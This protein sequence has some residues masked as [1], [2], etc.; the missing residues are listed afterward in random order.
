MQTVVQDMDDARR[1]T[2][3]ILAISTLL[4]V[5]AGIVLA[6]AVSRKITSGL[7][8]AVERAKVIAAGDLRGRDLLAHSQDEVGDLG[9][10]MNDMQHN[11]RSLLL[12]ITRNAESVASSSE[13]LS[14]AST[15]AAEGATAQSDQAT[16]VATAIQEMAAT[17]VEVSN[18][19]AKAA[20]AA[21]SA[22]QSAKHSGEVVGQALEGMRSIA[23]SVRITAEKIEELGKGSDRIGKVIG[24]IDEIADQTNLLALNAAI[25]AARAGEQGRGF[26]V[27]ADEV[28]KLAERTS[29]AT[30]EIAQMIET[31]Q[32]ETRAAV[33]NMQTGRRQVQEGVETTSKAGASLQEI[34]GA[35]EQVGDMVAQIAT[36]ATQ[37]TSTTEQINQSMEQIAKITHESAQGAQQSAKACQDLSGLAL[38]LQQ[39]VSQFKLENSETEGRANRDTTH[40]RQK[41]PRLLSQVD[42]RKRSFGHESDMANLGGKTEPGIK[43]QHP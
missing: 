18:N 22:A 31:V 6:F 37:Q 5:A 38:D 26:A 23:D 36:A 8:V 20:E 1:S 16:Q 43:V 41:E 27:V 21:R 25:E 30:Q 24:V 15:Q 11:L 35:A 14:S 29:K 39:L 3:W 2:Q 9:A 34:I 28:R 7:C 12:S 40:R 42:S 4:S 19:S 13:E 17:V 10:A 33:A 32:Q